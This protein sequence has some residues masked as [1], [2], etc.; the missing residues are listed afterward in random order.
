MVRVSLNG[1]QVTEVARIREEIEVDER[2]LVL[3][4]PMENE[5]RPNESG[6]T[7]DEY[8]PYRMHHLG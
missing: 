3:T 4:D 6:A 8:R 7:R 1:L 2:A 5:V